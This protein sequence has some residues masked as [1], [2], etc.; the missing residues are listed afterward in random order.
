MV[1]Q[2]LL[3][4][5]NY[6]LRL[7][8]IINSKNLILQT[9]GVEGLVGVPWSSR[10]VELEEKIAAFF[11]SLD[12]LDRLNATEKTMSIFYFVLC[13]FQLLRLIFQTSAHPRT[14]ILIDTL[15]LYSK[16]C[17]SSWIYVHFQCS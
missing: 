11:T 3:P 5:L 12:K 14:A 10:V 4:V 8:N 13:L 7:T 9:I 1:I 15:C 6:T 17:S 16:V 2:V